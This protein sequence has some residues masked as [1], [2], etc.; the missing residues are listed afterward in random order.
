MLKGCFILLLY[1]IT[2]TWDGGRKAVKDRKIAQ[3]STSYTKFSDGH[4]PQT[5]GKGYL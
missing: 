5:S 3:L 1:K 4:L 2:S